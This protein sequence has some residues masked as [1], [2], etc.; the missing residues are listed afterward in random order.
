MKGKELFESFSNIAY[1]LVGIA[2]LY[3]PNELKYEYQLLFCF[4]MQALSAASFTYHFVKSKP[5]YLF[6]W[7]AMSFVISIVTGIIADNP[8]GW[9][10]V[11]LWQ[12]I[13]SYFIL[14]RLNVYIEVGMSV[15]PCLIAILAMKSLL[16]FGIVI[17][18]F[19]FAFWMR[20]K[21]PDP[22]QAKFHDSWQHSVWHVL[23]ALG[24]YLAVVLP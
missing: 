9:A 17:A 23:T 22:K 6:D 24:F 20:S 21:D 16:T 10:F 14:G 12:F 18:I 19:L 4:A 13:Y 11:L 1:A 5:I 7:W 2:V 8:S 3:L 15:L